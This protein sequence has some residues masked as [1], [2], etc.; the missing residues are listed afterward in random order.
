M[1]PERPEAV[2]EV[3]I[4]GVSGGAPADMLGQVPVELVAG[5]G[6]AGFYRPTAGAGVAGFKA[7]RDTEAYSWGGLTSGAAARALWLLLLPFM[8]TNIAYWMRPRPPA[9]GRRI[10]RQALAWS[11][12][13]LARIVAFSLTVELVLAAT[14][15]ALDLV[16][17]QCAGE[18]RRCGAS[19]S[20]LR[21]LTTDGGWWEQPGRR[22]AVTAVLPLAVVAG[23]WYLA[24]RTWSSYE[25]QEPP[26]TT[27][28]PDGGGLDDPGF[29]RGTH[30][31]RRLRATHLALGISTVAC[32]LVWP[33]LAFDR[34]QGSGRATFGWLVIGALGLVVGTC[35]VLIG[36]PRF[37]D[38]RPNVT[39]DRLAFGSAILAGVA[40]ASAIAYA[41][42][43]RPA[44]SSA[45]QLPGFAGVVT[46][47]F[48]A[49]VA[50]LL[51]FAAV[52]LLRGRGA[53]ERGAI[54]GLAAPMT[55]TLGWLLGGAFSA[56]ISFRVA[57][58][59]DGP[60][61]PDAEGSGVEPPVIYAWGAFGFALEVAVVFVLLLV[62]VYAAW[63]QRRRQLDVVRMVFG[64]EADADPRRSR[65]IAAGLGNAKLADQGPRLLV[66]LLV[67]AV[68][69]AIATA[70]GFTQGLQTPSELVEDTSAFWQGTV[71][72][73]L[74][75]G[76]WLISAFALALVA[77]GRAAYGNGHLRRIVGILWDIGT[78]WPRAAHPLAPPCY[79][80]RTVP[81][82]L[83]RMRPVH[84]SGGLVLLS[85][86]SQGS[87]LA[88]AAALQLSSTEQRRSALLTYG[89]PLRRLY[90]RFFPAYLGVAELEALR[91]RVPW[92][93]N[94]WRRT[95]PIGGP[96]ELPGVD[97]ELPDPESFGRPP[98]DPAYPP[99]RG[100]SN[101]LQDPA[102]A[103][104]ATDATAAIA[105]HPDPRGMKGTFTP[106]HEA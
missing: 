30:P 72:F 1:V 50:A 36:L 14:G 85:G 78:F 34:D 67:P 65:T 69:V 61:T 10:G 7:D 46:G 83:I 26:G 15:V 45:G 32:V 97:V 51:L 74:Y 86:H 91:D 40:T 28:P 63:R 18:G 70:V 8:L 89:S 42:L 103:T 9:G 96:V 98:G 35:I 37:T 64:S 27:K 20:Y 100:H 22:L 75:V 13:L 17:W 92:W 19:R 93:R 82:L 53:A 76:S 94:L 55:A 95:D 68:L 21:F 47:L 99:I 31:V 81:D 29:W 43:S 71:S 54:G 5:D 88:A 24:R 4:H 23:L 104:L 2:L 101:Y 87:V 105:V 84:A 59:L 48:T 77:L 33:V 12:D 56:G 52:T 62:V 39:L 6:L 60:R 44:W 90:A 80:E 102:Y 57:D 58:W 16:G 66:A 3:R 11:F 41:M 73:L 106:T 49:Q 25:A 79:A 38:R